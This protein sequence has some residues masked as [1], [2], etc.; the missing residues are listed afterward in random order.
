MSGDTKDR[1]ISKLYL[2]G[3]LLLILSFF[4][5]II[6]TPVINNKLENKYREDRAI[7]EEEMRLYEEDLKLYNQ[8]QKAV[9]QYTNYNIVLCDVGTSAWQSGG[10]GIGNE[11]YYTFKINDDI[12][13]DGDVVGITLDKPVKFWGEVVEDDTLPD[14]G[15]VSY[16]TTFSLAELKGGSWVELYPSAHETRGPDAGNTAHFTMKFDIEAVDGFDTKI[17]MTA[18][19]KPIEPEKLEIKFWQV[20]NIPKWWNALQ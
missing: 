17:T 16:S 1:I 6:G 20:F 2:A 12:V 15:R 8:H 19:E 13:Y 7:Y 3:V 4:F 9:Y 11:I 18:P 10:G 5:V 14:V